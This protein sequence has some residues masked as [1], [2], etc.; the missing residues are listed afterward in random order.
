MDKD[1]D[2]VPIL[3]SRNI[4]K[5]QINKSKIKLFSQKYKKNIYTA[6]AED[7]QTRYRNIKKISDHTSALL[8]ELD[9]TLTANLP[10][11]LPLVIG[12][13]YFITINTATEIGLAN[14]SEVILKKIY[15]S[16]ERVQTAPGQYE[17]KCLPNCLIVQ[18][19]K[20][21]DK[22]FSNLEDNLIPIFTRTESFDLKLSANSKNDRKEGLRIRRTQFPLVPAYAYTVHKA[23]GKTLKKVIGTNL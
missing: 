10:T 2:E 21:T 18:L 16:N 14:G 12:A 7:Q 4:L 9:E 13:R 23:Q 3:V 17:F 8:K 11:Q 19:V 20:H 15:S 22:Q 5:T 1:W 6:N